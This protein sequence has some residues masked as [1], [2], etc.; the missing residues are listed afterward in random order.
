[1]GDK[2][3]REDMTVYLH[4]HLLFDRI[5]RKSHRI[6]QKKKRAERINP[7]DGGQ[8]KC[9]GPD[10]AKKKGCQIKILIETY[11]IGR[12]RENNRIIVDEF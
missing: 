7:V 9:A 5:S 8:K 6:D 3:A 11:G 4:L 10:E 12:E 1:M 2:R